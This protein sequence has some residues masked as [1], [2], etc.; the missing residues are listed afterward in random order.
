MF[1]S[2]SKGLTWE[3]WSLGSWIKVRRMKPRKDLLMHTF[4]SGLCYHSREHSSPPSSLNWGT[5]KATGI[6][7]IQCLTIKHLLS[8]RL[9]ANC[10]DCAKTDDCRELREIL[11]GGME[12]LKMGAW[13]HAGQLKTIVC[14]M[15][16]STVG[17]Q[18]Q[19]FRLWSWFC[20]IR[21]K[22]GGRSLLWDKT[23]YLHAKE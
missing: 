21:V 2:F 4:P 1:A 3:R 9:C 20:E 12:W 5:G 23:G 6:E 8:G 7:S 17:D 11:G 14:L 19:P 13:N 10:G 15:W 22:A 18:A 16:L